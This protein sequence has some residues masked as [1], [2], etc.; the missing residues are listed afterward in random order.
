MRKFYLLFTLCIWFVTAQS[1]NLIWSDEFNYTGL[2]DPAKWGYDTGNGG[3]GNNEW[4]N[5]T[6]NRLEN[7]RVEN[8]HLI[9]EARQD[10][11]DGIEY[12]SARLVTRDKGDWLYGRVEVRAKLPGGRG[13]W[14]A[15]WMLPT[16][17][18]YGG[19][20]NSGEIDIMENV[21]Y[22][23]NTVLGTVHTGAYN[24]LLGTQLGGEIDKTNYQ[25]DFHIY[26]I[27][28]TEDKMDFLID[29]EVYFTH[30]KHGGSPEWPFDKRFHL[31]LNLAVGGNWGA[32]LGVDPNI[33]P[34]RMTV[35]YVRVYDEVIGQPSTSLPGTLE[36]ENYTQSEGVQLE[37]CS[38]GGQNVGW[39]DAGDWM[40]YN[41]NVQTTGNYL[42]EYRVASAVGGGVINLEQNDGATLLGSVNV[43]NTNNWQGWETVSHTVYLDAGE[44]SIAIGVPVGGFNINWMKFTPQNSPVNLHIE[45]EDYAIMN[46]IQTENCSEGGQN[47]GYTDAGDWLVFDA[48]ISAGNYTVS[49]RVASQNGGGQIQLEQAGGGA[50]FGVTNVNVT[51]GWQAWTTITQQVTIPQNLTQFAISIPAGGFNLNWVEFSSNSGSRQ[52][53]VTLM[54]QISPQRVS[55]YPNPAFSTLTVESNGFSKASI[56]SLEGREIQSHDLDIND[57]TLEMDVSNL[58]NGIYII[59]MV[60]QIGT[61]TY[62]FNKQ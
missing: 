58:Q 4:Q 29:N 43:P 7:A 25:S 33:W 52:N 49:Y 36:A 37:N 24:H 8:G 2:P 56:I 22:D 23:P 45:A 38:E 62:R 44:Q 6:A 14:A 16:D 39:I 20:P 1:Q 9:V 42:V 54:E 31:I 40:K 13:T 32:A 27:D 61:E 34:Q 19:W 50:V 47:I 35:D 60:G 57:M 28:W 51:G 59:R 5:Y 10:W 30:T 12:S 18:E 15:I 48:D 41:V 26:A 11:H 55:I 21:G 53:D 3:F 17:W 46:G